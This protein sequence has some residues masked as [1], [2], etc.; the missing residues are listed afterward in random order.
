MQS[1]YGCMEGSLYDCRS[2]L[3]LRPW[4]LPAGTNPLP[5]SL[6]QIYFR[7]QNPIAHTRPFGRGAWKL[8]PVRIGSG[9]WQPGLAL[10]Y[11][12]YSMKLSR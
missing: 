12:S 1:Q 9:V 8:E 5:L 7:T 6:S 4:R 3:A 11:C 2:L 10:S